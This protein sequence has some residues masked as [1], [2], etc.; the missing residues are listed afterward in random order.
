MGSHRWQIA[1]DLMSPCIG[2]PIPN[3]WPA[4]IGRG[5]VT[6]LKFQNYSSGFGDSVCQR[7]RRVIRHQ[8]H[9]GLSPARR[10]H[11]HP[12]LD[13]DAWFTFKADAL[14]SALWSVRLL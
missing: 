12:A 14:T 3:E 9:V 8:Q 6:R 2:D 11:Q 4:I 1:S 5:S 13:L 7:R 10:R